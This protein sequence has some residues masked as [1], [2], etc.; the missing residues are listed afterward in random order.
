MQPLLPSLAALD[1]PRLAK[2]QGATPS[3]RRVESDVKDRVDP[4]FHFDLL[5]DELKELVLAQ[6]IDSRDLQCKDVVNLCALLRCGETEWQHAC[7][8]RGW[9]DKLPHF[10]WRGWFMRQCYRADVLDRNLIEEARKNN[11]ENVRLLLNVGADVNAFDGQA[12]RQAVDRQNVNLVT[13]LLAG[14]AN[15]NVRSS[16]PIS[17]PL[18]LTVASRKGN[19]EIVR[20]LLKHGV[21]VHSHDDEALRVASEHGNVGV[22]RV[23]VL[24]HHADVHAKEDI[25]LGDASEQGQTDV[26]SFLLQHGAN[27][28][29]ADDYALRTAS[30]QGHYD[31]VTLL[32]EAGANVHAA[33]NYALEAAEENG[34][35]KVA[36]LLRE[37]GAQ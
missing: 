7:T 14:G 34:F 3:S 28:H 29:A 1:S 11:I 25:A 4:A 21:N 5:T 13:T 16:R 19:V 15:A 6:A 27:V 2:R 36:E 9:S 17:R 33:D 20:L 37:Y 35:D 31:V 12:L 26:V 23:L 22:V 18:L 8:S 30:D 10:T 24:E 32:L